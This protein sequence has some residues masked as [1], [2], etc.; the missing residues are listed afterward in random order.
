MHFF[1]PQRSPEI[2]NYEIYFSFAI[3]VFRLVTKIDSN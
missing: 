2:S 1:K 3:A